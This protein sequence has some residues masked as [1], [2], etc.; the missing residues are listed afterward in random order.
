MLIP[1]LLYGYFCLCI[2][3]ILIRK[4]IENSLMVKGSIFTSDKNNVHLHSSCRVTSFETGSKLIKIAPY[5]N[6]SAIYCLTTS[7]GHQTIE[8]S[9]PYLQTNRSF[10]FNTRQSIVLSFIQECIQR[11]SL[12]KKQICNIFTCWRALS[13]TEA[14]LFLKVTPISSV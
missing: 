6:S 5:P 7:R 9:M 1:L 12:L 13:E 14:S 3:R 11:Y 10:I 2:I 4:N 8:F